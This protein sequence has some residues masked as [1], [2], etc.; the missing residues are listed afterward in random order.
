MWL[1]VAL[2]LIVVGAAVFH[3]LLALQSPV[4][5]VMPDEL[6]Y[7]ELAKSLGSGSLPA[8]RDHGTFGF[9]LG[10]PLLLAPIWALF[11]D[12]SSAYVAAKL[13]NALIVSLTAIPA[14]ALARRFVS[15]QRALVVAALAVSVPGLLYAGTLMTESVLYPLFVLALLAIV[16]A[17][18][19][20][21]VMTQ[22]FVF[23]AIALAAFVKVHSLVLAAGYVGAVLLYHA[24][25]VRQLAALRHRLKAYWL[26]W[27]VILGL[28]L[29]VGFGAVLLRRNPAE[30]LGAYANV[31]TELD[32]GAIPWRTLVYVAE[33]DLSLAI[34]P[35]AAAILVIISGVRQSAER[36]FRLLASL[37]L[38]IA[39]VW[40]LT[41]AVYSSNSTPSEF[42]YAPGAGAN[43]RATF[44]LAPLFLIALLLWLQERRAAR[45]ILI[46][47]TGVA[48]VLPATMPLAAFSAVGNL[49]IQG[50][51]SIVWR[52]ID[53]YLQWPA[54]VLLF[55][56]VV[57]SF[58]ILVVRRPLRDVV[59]VFPLLTI[60]LVVTLIAQTT[61]V[62]SSEWARSVAV[63]TPP[64]WIDDAVGS[65]RQVSVLWYEPP[66][67]PYAPHA[68]RHRVLWLG[69]FF[70]HSVGSVYE[71]GSPIAY[72]YE[73]PATPVQLRDGEVVSRD[74]R[75][76]A[77]GHLVLAPCQVSVAG[78]QVA[79][80]V[81]T[82]ATV[83]RVGKTVRARV[84]DPQ[85]CWGDAEP[86][87][88]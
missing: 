20:P 53:R 58:F 48:A 64:S 80:D 40:L 79:H 51:S 42:G 30:G 27:Y 75:P 3:A 61:L 38:A 2:G 4:P 55:G 69:E 54:S 34:A 47:A 62:V 33:L 84:R 78:E 46:V 11:A 36:G 65:D 10:Y 16:G 26:T 14:Y 50:F 63:G 17:I 66:G 72:G 49:S 12:V 45:V 18:E 81:A 71:I 15:P 1:P 86:R 21:T 85:L 28:C 82:R 76:L 37:T 7:S 68:A 39:A 74:G 57:G 60:Y 13:V 44:V 29:A 23:G 87:L 52:G 43:E 9:G 24:L 6:R 67:Q 22:A 70:N 77:L 31:A 5:W 19:R 83:Y 25:E 73:L 56:L 35:F 88:R 41:I 59:L 32:P 8:I